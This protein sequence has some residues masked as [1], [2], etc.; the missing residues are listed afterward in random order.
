M[1]SFKF[2]K[3]DILLDIK[4][5]ETTFDFDE[6]KDKLNKAKSSLDEFYN[7][8]AKSGRFA[9]LW[10]QYDPF[11][12]ISPN[13]N[14]HGKEKIFNNTKIMV[15]F[16]GNTYNITNAWIKCYELVNYY[17]L[18]NIKTFHF[19][20]AAFPGSFILATRHFCLEK[21][22]SY[23]WVASSLITKNELDSDSLYDSYKLWKHYPEHWIMGAENNGDVLV[24]ENQLDFMDK[25]KNNITL[26]TSDLGFD[27]SDDFSKQEIAQAPPNIG[28]ILSGILTLQNGGNFITKQYTFFEPITI[29]VMLLVSQLFEEF[30][31]CKPY[32]SR[33]LNSETYLVGKGFKGFNKS[34]KYWD[35]MFEILNINVNT[36]LSLFGKW[37]DFPEDYRKLIKEAANIIF[38]KQVEKINK[39]VKDIKEN[40]LT[41]NVSGHQEQIL[42]KQWFID[43]PISPILLGE[44]LKMEDKFDQK[45]ILKTL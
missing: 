28:Q 34:H 38:N 33:A 10:K 35:I 44:Q 42:I 13:I 25:L 45:K 16:C 11:S 15:A 22:Y 41:S 14:M 36:N 21:R 19:D 23:D 12:V 9:Y 5:E 3:Y 29:S 39:A 26:Y 4:K 7:D 2:P 8:K 31:V 1:L 20:N 43:N 37:E 17:K 6:L 27:V 24:K 30:Y 18:V 40:W 32:S